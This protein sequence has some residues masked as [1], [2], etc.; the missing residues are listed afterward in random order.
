[1]SAAG[2]STVPSHGPSTAR[3]PGLGASADPSTTPACCVPHHPISAVSRMGGG[4][5]P[6]PGVVCL[7]EQPEFKRHVLEVLCQPL[8]KGII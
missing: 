7:D 3:P 4:A 6:R 8:E 1:M 5:V 2:R